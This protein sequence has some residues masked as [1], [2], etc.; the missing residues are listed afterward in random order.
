MHE[1]YQQQALDALMNHGRRGPAHA[2]EILA[3]HGAERADAESYCASLLP[4]A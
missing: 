2:V 3:A 1:G 4:E